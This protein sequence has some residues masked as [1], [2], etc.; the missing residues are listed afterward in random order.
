[1]LKKNV[2]QLHNGHMEELS[3]MNTEE[4]EKYMEY[5]RVQARCIKSR[6]PHISMDDL[7]SY[8]YMGLVDALSKWNPESGATFKTYAYIRIRGCIMDYIRKEGG[9]SRKAVAKYNRL[10]E[11]GLDVGASVCEIAQALGISNAK[12]YCISVELQAPRVEESYVTDENV[13]LKD[14]IQCALRELPEKERY[15]I[16]KHFIEDYS[17]AEIAEQMG[18][19]HNWVNTLVRRAL[20]QMRCS[21]LRE[22]L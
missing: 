12:A 14:A 11:V 13:L 4:L 21:T 9:Y 10:R 1:M 20:K 19:S 17:T 16:V 7:Q 2:Q 8:A 6:Y 15:V 22:F 5:A 3:P 18:V